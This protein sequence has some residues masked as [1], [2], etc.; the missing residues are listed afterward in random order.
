MCTRIPGRS[1]PGDPFE[2]T[3]LRRD[4]ADQAAAA[5]ADPGAGSAA[6]IPAWAHD[7]DGLPRVRSAGPWLATQGRFFPDWGRRITEAELA[8][9]AVDE[10]TASA[11]IQQ[12]GRP[13]RSTWH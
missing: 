5:D 11:A 4:L 9:A 8:A 1:S 10:A 6:R 13:G 3:V 7:E 12:A 2:D